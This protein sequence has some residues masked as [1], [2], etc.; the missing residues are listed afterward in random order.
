MRPSQWLLRAGLLFSLAL[1]AESGMIVVALPPSGPGGAVG[2]FNPK[3][4]GP[5]NAAENWCGYEQ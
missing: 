4:D 2:E 3:P 5:A 1:L